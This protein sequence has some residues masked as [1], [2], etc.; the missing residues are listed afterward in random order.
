MGL[1]VA[2]CFAFLALTP[3][4]PTPWTTLGTA[5]LYIYLLHSFVLYPIRQWSWFQGNSSGWVL[6]AAIAFSLVLPFLLGNRVVTRILR[7]LVEPRLEW[8]FRRSE[9]RVPRTTAHD[10]AALEARSLSASSLTAL[11]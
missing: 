4:R 6:I 9:P 7:P 5:T 2:L 11:R 1:A 8:L 10:S 3:R